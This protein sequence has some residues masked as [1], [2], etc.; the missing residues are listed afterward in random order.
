MLR[1]S[2]A[3]A[4]APAVGVCHGSGRGGVEAGQPG[5]RARGRR[6]ADR[7]SVAHESV[8]GRARQAED[9]GE[10]RKEPPFALIE[11]AVGLAHTDCE[12]EGKLA[13]VRLAELDSCGFQPEPAK[14]HVLVEADEIHLRLAAERFGHLAHMLAFSGALVAVGERRQQADGDEGSGL[15]GGHERT[16]QVKNGSLGCAPRLQVRLTSCHDSA[17]AGLHHQH[18]RA[19]PSR[20]HRWPFVRLRPITGRGRVVPP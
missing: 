13:Q 8:G 19:A 2:S 11:C 9:L 4:G 7:F 14:Q 10:A 5:E 12:L 6:G 20:H 16:P 18:T 17:D 3:A 1:S 15:L